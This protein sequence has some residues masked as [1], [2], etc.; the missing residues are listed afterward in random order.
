MSHIFSDSQSAVSSSSAS[1]VALVEAGKPMQIVEM[2][3]RAVQFHQAGCL[4]E[5]EGLYREVLSRQPKNADAL[6]FLGVVSYQKGDSKNAILLLSK[7]LK[8]APSSL[9]CHN[10][11]GSVYSKIGNYKKA[12]FHFRKALK[13]GGGSAETWHNLGLMQ[14]RKGDQEA[15]LKHFTKA[16][17]IDSNYAPPLREMGIIYMLRH[18]FSAAES[19]YRGYLALAPHDM[20]ICN[21]LGYVVQM[22]GRLGEAEALFAQALEQGS[23]S[24]ELGYNM[25]LLLI[26]QGR[27]EEARKLFRQQ[28]RDDPDTWTIELGLAVVMASRGIYDEALQNM[29]DILE[30]IPDDAAVWTGIGMTLISLNKFEEAIKVLERAIEIDPEMAMAHN[31][32]GS[33]YIQSNVPGVA[34]HHLKKAIA[35][36]PDY[37]DPYLNLCRALRS[38]HEYDQANFFGRAALDLKSYEGR[39]FASLLQVFRATADFDALERL[40][41]IWENAIALDKK[42]LPTI[43]LDLLVCS[44]TEQELQKFFDLIAIWAEMVEKEAAQAPLPA[45]QHKKSRAKLRVGFLSSDLR[46]HSVSRFL[47]PLMLHYDRNRF[48]FFCY[49]PVQCIGDPIQVLI[50][51]SVDSFTFVNDMSPREIASVIQKDDVDILFELNGFTTH[52]K[53]EALAYRPAPVQM[54]WLGYPFTCGLSTIDHV[55]MDQYVVPE[56]GKYLVEEPIIMPDAWVCFGNFADVEIT[57][58]LPMDRYGSVTFGTLN[59]PYKYTPEM[60]SNWARVMREVPNSRFLI[61]RPEAWSLVLCKNMSN[62]FAKHG[63]DSDRLFFF[64]NKTQKKNHLFY[65]NEIDISLDTFPLTGGTTTCEALW[66]GVPVVSLVGSAFQQ[67]ISYSALMQCGLDELCTFDTEGFVA[68]AVELAND[69]EKLLLWRHELRD[70]MASLPLCDHER[71]V[72]QFQEMLDQVAKHHGLR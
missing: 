16:N 11:I 70:H 55:V 34:A 30:I 56:D 54:S 9:S 17:E 52:S 6:Q 27:T 72:H 24:S 35:L 1:T 46:K 68:K 2:L 3:S 53:L 18:D 47:T 42:H 25:R 7:A 59:N 49:C 19:A 41:S 57:P 51:E 38:I 40:G 58:G 45:R 20:A 39:F 21:N 37:I 32:L 67:R 14:R 36:K 64:D 26:G 23:Q 31:N 29:K 50:Q 43:F 65:Y 28:L 66:M 71:F 8:M 12:E 62:E 60:I 48:E 5:A 15:A 4:E 10:N 22:Q 44:S 61:V 13:G 33:A 63:V 69:R